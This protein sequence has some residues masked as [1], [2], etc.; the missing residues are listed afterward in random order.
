MRNAIIDRVAPA[1]AAVLRGRLPALPAMWE[2]EEA[3]WHL[4]WRVPSGRPL[5][6][7][8]MFVDQQND[9]TAADLKLALREGFRSIEHVKRYTTTGMGTDQGKTSNVPAL[10]IVAETTGV[11]LAQADEVRIHIAQPEGCAPIADAIM[12]EA[13][14]IE[15]CTPTT[16]AHSLAI[17]APGD[18]DEAVAIAAA[19]PAAA[20]GQV[21]VRP[22]RVL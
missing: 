4:L 17:G 15:A 5:H 21:E 18:L 6:K 2:A 12:T 16:V 9:V 10:G 22:V 19:H 20:F 1:A 8:K 13:R 7:S 11:T 14:E 3:P